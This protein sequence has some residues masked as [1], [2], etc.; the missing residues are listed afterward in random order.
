MI[1]SGS[2]LLEN[3]H[4]TLSTVCP[5]PSYANATGAHLVVI[6]PIPGGSLQVDITPLGAFPAHIDESHH[7]R[8]ITQGLTRA[9]PCTSPTV[10]NFLCLL[11]HRARTF[12]ARSI[13]AGIQA[14]H[15]GTT[16]KS[17]LP[18]LQ[19]TSRFRPIISTPSVNT[20]FS[21]IR[22]FPVYQD[23]VQTVQD[24]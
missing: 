18:L 21:A 11:F 7:S 9:Y 1:S 10:I 20:R 3:I 17:P 14:A 16:K 5:H 12:H 24:S 13:P 15:P 6:V 4:D 22:T 23:R 19:N 8:S 2:Q